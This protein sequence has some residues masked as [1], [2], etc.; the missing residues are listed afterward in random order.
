MRW[1][2][3]SLSRRYPGTGEKR[4]TSYLVAERDAGALTERLIYFCDEPDEWTGMGK[5]TRAK[6][7]AEFDRERTNDD[8]EVLYAQVSNVGG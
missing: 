4:R 2:I 7:E 3:E 6:I 5:R 8:L 1:C